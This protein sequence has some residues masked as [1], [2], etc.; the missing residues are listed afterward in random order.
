[1]GIN[2]ENQHQELLFTDLKYS[3]SFNPTY[4]KL[5]KEQKNNFENK[6]IQDLNFIQFNSA[7]VIIGHEKNTFCFDNEQPSH[8]YFLQPFKFANRLISNG[9]Y[10]QF[11]V[12]GGYNR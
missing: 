9:E 8:R 5:K 6:K 12:D 7:D 4:P 2:H 3:F 10:L 1:L 11:V